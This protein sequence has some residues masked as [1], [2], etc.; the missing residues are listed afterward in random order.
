MLH[1]QYVWL[2]PNQH[3][4]FLLQCNAFFYVRYLCSLLVLSC[5]LAQNNYTSIHVERCECVVGENVS[6]VE[7]VKMV[8]IYASS[9]AYVHWQ[10]DG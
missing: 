4:G 1:M 2:L 6:L 9:Y 10:C 8:I 5:H 7:Q 3:T